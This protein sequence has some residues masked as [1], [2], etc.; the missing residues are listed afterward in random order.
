M[1]LCKGEGVLHRSWSVRAQG[2]DV[3]G[4]LFGLSL[5]AGKTLSVFWPVSIRPTLGGPQLLQKPTA[6]L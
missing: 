4:D 1:W 3:D 2:R 5:P 6:D